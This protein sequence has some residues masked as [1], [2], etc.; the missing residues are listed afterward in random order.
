MFGTQGGEEG[1][2]NE[3]I[4]GWHL[5]WNEW[6][7]E[8]RVHEP[9][10]PKDWQSVGGGWDHVTGM[11]LQHWDVCWSWGG[12]G[13]IPCRLDVLYQQ[14]HRLNRCPT[15]HVTMVA[16][17][18]QHCHFH[19]AEGCVMGAG[20]VEMEE[21]SGGRWPPA[22]PRLEEGTKRT[23]HPTFF[24]KKLEKHPKTGGKHGFP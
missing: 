7:S 11:G 24:L 20:E 8:W 18:T 4:W 1:W 9:K 2:E 10:R 22:L 5:V 17:S 6:M 14:K 19:R 16:S 21:E 12:Q 23:L 3:E 15:V 13:G